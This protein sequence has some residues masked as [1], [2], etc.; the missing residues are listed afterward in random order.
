MTRKFN[1]LETTEYTDYTEAAFAELKAKSRKLKAKCNIEPLNTR[2]TNASPPGRQ[3]QK[4]SMMKQ[5][6]DC[7]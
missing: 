2:E 3:Y 7:Y 1:D 6:V 5:D 4:D